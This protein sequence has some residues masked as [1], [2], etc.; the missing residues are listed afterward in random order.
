MALKDFWSKTNSWLQAHKPFGT[1]D[2]QPQIDDQG[3]ISTDTESTSQAESVVEEQTVQDNQLTV[4]AAQP[5]DKSESFEKLQVGFGKLIGQLQGINENLNR[6]IAQHE[7]LMARMD[8]L[9]DLLASFPRVVEDQKD[10]TEKLFEQLKATDIKNEQFI[11]TI[12]KIPTETA[13]QTDAL[14]EANQHLAAS[15]DSDVQMAEN[16]NKFNQ[17]LGNLNRNTAGQTDSIMQMSKTFATSDRY[18]KYIMSIQNKRFMWIFVS[19]ISVCVIVVLIL[20]GV[21]IYIRR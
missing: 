17:T 5:I 16:L 2:Y 12:E 8:N 10:L 9:P 18:L 13:K 1:K 3:L 4:K 11:E 19:A 7:N 20:A 21:I 14:V 15:V 6:Q